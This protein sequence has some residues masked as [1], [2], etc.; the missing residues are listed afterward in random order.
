[1]NKDV[2]TLEK[3]LPLALDREET[4]LVVVWW[5]EASTQRTRLISGEI[6]VWQIIGIPV[7]L[8]AVPA[9]RAACDIH[10]D[11]ENQHPHQHDAKAIL[12]A[13]HFLLLGDIPVYHARIKDKVN[14]SRSA[15]RPTSSRATSEEQAPPSCATLTT[16]GPFRQMFSTEAAG[17]ALPT[18]I[19]VV[20]TGATS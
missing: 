20:Q 13:D 3:H 12:Q 16:S 8:K 2:L 18:A 19:E 1:M 11:S 5:G 15:N 10:R 9:I 17:A 14:A 6:W 7:P 4:Q